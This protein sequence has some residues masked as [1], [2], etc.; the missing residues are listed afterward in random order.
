M[1][2]FFLLMAFFG[3][4][5]AMVFWW[6]VGRTSWDNAWGDGA[7]FVWKAVGFIFV[8]WT[9]LMFLVLG[10]E[11]INGWDW[12]LIGLGLA[13]DALS[14]ANIIWRRGRDVP[15]QYSQYVPADLR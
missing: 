6:I 2:C 11:P 7:S 4:R 1:C 10:G 9:T 8:P 15:E 5:T 3:P 12:L 13:A 14:W